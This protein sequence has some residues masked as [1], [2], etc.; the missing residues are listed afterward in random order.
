MS[1]QIPFKMGGEL[2]GNWVRIGSTPDSG[3]HYGGGTASPTRGE[4]RD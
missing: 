1:R 3:A 2:G 4:A